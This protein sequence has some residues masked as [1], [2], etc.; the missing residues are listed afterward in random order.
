VPDACDLRAGTSHDFDGNQVPDECDPLFAS[1]DRVSIGT[2]GQASFV[3]A[4]GA[5][6]AGRAYRLLGSMS[7][8]TPPTAFGPVLL[9]LQSQNDLWFQLTWSVFSPALLQ[10]TVGVLDTAGRA[11]AA[12]VVPPLP[13]TLLGLQF[14]HAFLVQDLSTLQYTFASNAVPLLLVP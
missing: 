3:L 7:G 14:H 2:G 1:T 8:T 5:A 9:P 11:N 13:A 12:I 10:G 6:H 4:A